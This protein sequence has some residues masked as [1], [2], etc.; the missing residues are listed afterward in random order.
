MFFLSIFSFTEIV[1]IC[2]YFEIKLFHITC[3]CNVIIN[4]KMANSLKK[5]ALRK[6]YFCVV[7][8]MCKYINNNNRNRNHNHNTI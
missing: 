3:K 5:I 2:F 8:C 7:C 6:K 4:V 1:L